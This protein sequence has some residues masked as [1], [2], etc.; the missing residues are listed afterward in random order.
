MRRKLL[1]AAIT[2]TTLTP[3]WA[4]VQTM[5]S[6]EMVETY[7]EDS[8]V[9]VV[10]RQQQKSEADREKI[11]RALTISPGEPVLSEAEE[12]AYREALQRYLDEGKKD[13]LSDAEE[14]FLRRAL[15]LPVDELARAQPPADFTPRTLPIIFGQ[16]PEIPDEP[17][18]QTF[19]NDQLGIGFDGQNLNFSIGN[20]PGIDQIQ[21]PEAINEGPIT[22]TPR[23]GGGFDLSIK[24]PD[25]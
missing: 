16:Q 3:A 2:A 24:V 25:Q 8:A 1:A 5:T 22:L 19:L 17:F 7:V 4:G 23:P 13:A 15:L 10:P 6:D 11:I 14:E 12:E 21:I 18:T 9:I 20:P